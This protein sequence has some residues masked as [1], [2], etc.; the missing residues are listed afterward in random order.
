VRVSAHAL[1]RRDDS[2]PGL[3]EIGRAVHPGSHVAES[4]AIERRVGRGRVVAARL[5]PAHPGGLRQAR[6]VGDDVR[7]VL[8]AVAGQLHVP[9]VV[10]T[11]ITFASRGDSEIEKI[12]VCISAA[13]LST[14]MPP[15][16]SCF[17]FSG[18]FVSGR[19]KCAPSC[20]RGR[21]SG[22]GTAS[23]DR[24]CLSASVTPQSACSSCSGA[25]PCSRLRLDVA[26]RSGLPV[27]AAD[28]AALRF[29]IRGVRVGPVRDRPDPSPP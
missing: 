18:S 12:V 20:H 23:R 9:V 21:A 17:C 24:S 13:E 14:V 16:S 5:D 1:L 26:P 10:P 29:G 22:R 4:V 3:A 8:R 6:H 15:D 19:E 7:P 2:L 25:S 28:V 27:D 11:Q